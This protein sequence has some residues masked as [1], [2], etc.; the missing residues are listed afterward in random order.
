MWT[1]LVSEN[2]TPLLDAG[3]KVEVDARDDNE[4]PHG[5]IQS[6]REASLPYQALIE[7]EFN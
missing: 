1:P 5:D 3:V 7:A 2:E 6:M 4:L